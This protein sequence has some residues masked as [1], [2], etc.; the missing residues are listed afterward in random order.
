MLHDTSVIENF[1]KHPPPPPPPTTKNNMIT[2]T[3]EFDVL[4]W[5]IASDDRA[6]DYGS[7]Q[8]TSS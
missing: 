2:A 7:F 8:N 6:N 5:K 1:T 3:E 4:T